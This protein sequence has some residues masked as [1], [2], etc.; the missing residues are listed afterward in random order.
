VVLNFG[1]KIGDGS[2]QEVQ[3]DPHVQK[4]FLG[5]ED[6]KVAVS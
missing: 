5:Q 4:A 1:G 2:P 6:V 3:R